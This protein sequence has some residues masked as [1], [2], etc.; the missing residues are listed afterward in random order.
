[1]S[2]LIPETELRDQLFKENEEFRKLA[3]EHE[4]Y[5]NQL[6]DLGNKH[7]LSKDDELLEKTLKKRKLALKDQMF[8]MVQ[9]YRKQMEK[10]A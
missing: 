2:S 1:M 9:Q 4:A 7:F 3:I 10:Q 5:D 8:S 6:E